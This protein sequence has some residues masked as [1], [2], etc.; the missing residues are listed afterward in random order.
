MV[1]DYIKKNKL[2]NPLK[3]KYY[4]TLEE[5]QNNKGDNEVLLLNSKEY[6]N[7]HY[8][9]EIFFVNDYLYNKIIIKGD[10]HWK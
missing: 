2:R 10:F 4:L 6:K 9:T 5:L 3:V 7:G 8:T 1:N